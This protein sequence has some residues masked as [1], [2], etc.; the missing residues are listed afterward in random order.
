MANYVLAS[1]FWRCVSSLRVLSSFPVSSCLRGLSSSL[2]RRVSA[3]SRSS[4]RL[5]RPSVVSATHGS[6]HWPLTTGPHRTRQRCSGPVC[7]RPSA[8]R[9]V[10]SRQNRLQARLEAAGSGFAGMERA[11]TR[12]DGRKQRRNSADGCGEDRASDEVLIGVQR[13]DG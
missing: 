8:S 2:S 11:G 12:S 10:P 3:A 9:P 13:A 6:S 1:A 4:C 5:S 7:N